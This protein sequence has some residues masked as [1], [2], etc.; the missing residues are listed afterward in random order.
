MA[1][2]KGISDPADASTDPA[3]SVCFT[4]IVDGKNLGYFSTCEGLGVEVVME[5]R[6]EGG[7]N[8][9]I[10]QLPSRI[11]YSNVKLSRAV[12]KDSHLITDWLVSFANEVT[13]KTACI[14]AM[15][16]EGKVVASWSLDG[17]MPVRWSGP[18]LNLDSPK[19]AMET[20][21]LAHHGFL[22]ETGARS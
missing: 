17:V 7:N 15:T 1:A 12:G 21:E 10:W 11:K 19:V 2:A 6:E 18:S 5:Q 14:S 20:L 13:R 16:G 9:F 22:P 3:V 8:G 4:V